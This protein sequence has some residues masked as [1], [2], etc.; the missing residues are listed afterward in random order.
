M[1]DH[2]NYILQAQQKP[3]PSQN[4]ARAAGFVLIFLLY[5]FPLHL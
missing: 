2:S 1:S 3:I 4:P 5:P